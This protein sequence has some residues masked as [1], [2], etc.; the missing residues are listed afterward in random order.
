MNI[1]LGLV[2][3]QIS[4]LILVI[5]IRVTLEL[6]ERITGTD[7]QKNVAPA[8]VNNLSDSSDIPNYLVDALRNSVECLARNDSEH[9]RV[10]IQYVIREI[11]SGSYKFIK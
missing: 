1:L 6:L 9:A 2:L 5:T 7:K 10:M 11:V 3:G 4:L 8:V